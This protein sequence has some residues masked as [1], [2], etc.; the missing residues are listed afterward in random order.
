MLY[1]FFLTIKE[2]IIHN[3]G[4]LSEADIVALNYII[5]HKHLVFFL[6]IHSNDNL[7]ISFRVLGLLFDN[8]YQ[9]V[10]Q[11]KSLLGEKVCLLAAANHHK[12]IIYCCNRGTCTN[13]SDIAYVTKHSSPEYMRTEFSVADALTYIHGWSFASRDGARLSFSGLKFGKRTTLIPFHSDIH[14]AMHKNQ[15]ISLQHENFATSLTPLE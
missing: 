10:M 8:F 11:H 6:R 2:R 13:G 4:K 7:L 3:M 15:L 1:A 12:T 14:V 5:V 9:R